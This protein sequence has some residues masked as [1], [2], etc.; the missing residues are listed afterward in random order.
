MEFF[1]MVLGSMSSN[2]NAYA[3]PWHINTKEY[4][5]TE[6]SYPVSKC[7]RNWWS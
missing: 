1:S 5:L 4:D 2:V 6:Q 7:L 3:K